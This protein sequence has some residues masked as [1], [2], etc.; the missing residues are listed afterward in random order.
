MA[1]AREQQIPRGNDRKKSK[2]GT[3]RPRRDDN[4][5]SKGNGGGFGFELLFFGGASGEGGGDLVE[6][7]GADKAVVVDSAVA[8]V[9]EGEL[10]LLE[11]RRLVKRSSMVKRW[12]MAERW[13]AAGRAG[14]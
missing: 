14:A 3:S 5:K 7:G 10:A 6:V 9:G 11:V 13:P 1:W 4:Q 12:P 8:L 2:C